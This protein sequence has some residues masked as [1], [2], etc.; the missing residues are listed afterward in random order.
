MAGIGS[1][2]EGPL[3]AALKQWYARPGDRLETAVDGFVVDIVR[4]EDLIEIQTG[5]FAAI[6]AKLTTLLQSHP[7]RVVYPITQDKWIVRPKTA[8]SRTVIRRKS[9][10]RGRLH[11]LFWELVSI[12]QLLSHPRFSLELLVI[13]EEEAWRYAGKRQWRRRGW[14]VAERRLLGVLERRVFGAV[15]DWRGLLP[16]GVTAFTARELASAL[17]V[18]TVLAQKIAYC[19]NKGNVIEL[20]GRQGRANV[21]RVPV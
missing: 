1:L 15:R 5:H 20:A 19:L 10:K 12:P 16:R 13:Q 18:G 8:R 11:D 9:P 7:V 2:N 3:H 21:Y 17:G 4:G 14:G 6:R